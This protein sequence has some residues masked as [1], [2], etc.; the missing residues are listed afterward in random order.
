MGLYRSRRRQMV[1]GGCRQMLAETAG[2]MC[3]RCI[4]RCNLIAAVVGLRCRE[5]LILHVA[6]AAALGERNSRHHAAGNRDPGL[7][8][9]AQQDHDRC[10]VLPDSHGV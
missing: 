8:R 4:S 2:D 6:R 1:R 3:K 9:Q 5:R 7:S 10:N